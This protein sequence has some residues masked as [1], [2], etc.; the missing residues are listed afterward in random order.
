M[1]HGV[2][3]ILNSSVYNIDPSSGFLPHIQVKIEIL[4]PVHTRPMYLTY[5]LEVTIMSPHFGETHIN[6]VK[7]RGII[8]PLAPGVH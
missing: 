2:L 4:P 5:T 3:R 1:L 8:N 7:V 6:Q